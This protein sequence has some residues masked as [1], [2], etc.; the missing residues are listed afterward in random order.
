MPLKDVAFSR[1]PP[2]EYDQA[3]ANTKTSPK[4]RSRRWACIS[5]CGAFLLI[6]AV[7]LATASALNL[8]HGAS[9]STWSTCGHSLETARERDCSFDLISFAWQT[10]ECYDGELV[11]E[12]A[13][14][15]NWTFYADDK[16]TA[17]VSQEI[18]LQGDRT[19]LFVKWDYHLVHC[20]FMWRQMHRAYERGW[21]DNHL[22]NYNHT[23]H[24]Q[25]MMLMDSSAADHAI[26]VA[27]VIYPRCDRVLRGGM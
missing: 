7:V 13:S 24:C 18:A 15:T 22:G 21:I 1:L 8:R 5:A 25:K 2:D 26:T 19:P 17:P 9:A 3:D 20:T 4:A 16:F 12:F 6:I 11:A 27:Q 23:L 14:W 10:P